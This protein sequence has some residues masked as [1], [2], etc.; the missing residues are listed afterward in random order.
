MAEDPRV[1][2]I[3]VEFFTDVFKTRFVPSEFLRLVLR[4]RRDRHEDRVNGRLF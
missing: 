1:A 2:P 4:Q 3:L